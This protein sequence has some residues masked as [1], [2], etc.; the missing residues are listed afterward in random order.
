MLYKKG[1]PA[2]CDNYRPI[3]LLRSCGVHRSRQWMKKLCSHQMR[4][5]YIQ[6]LC[7]NVPAPSETR[8]CRAAR[9]EHAVW[10]QVKHGN[11]RCAL[12]GE[13]HPRGSVGRERRVRSVV[14]TGLGKG[15]RLHTSG[16]V[17]HCAPTLRRARAFLTHGAK[18]LQ[19]QNIPCAGRG[20]PI[21]SAPAARRRVPGARSTRFSS[22]SS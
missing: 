21:A 2:L 4:H 14:G 19:E 10:L 16:C 18:H 15:L 5:T 13:T 12:H 1:D 8:W 6:N 7:G 9:V 20:R 17:A 22:L 3:S 11:R